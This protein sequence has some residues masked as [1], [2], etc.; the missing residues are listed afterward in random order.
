MSE[1]EKDIHINAPS[2]RETKNL[3]VS[4]L[5]SFW[6]ELTHPKPNLVMRTKGGIDRTF[7]LLIILL[8]LVGSIMIFSSSYVYSAKK[9]GDAM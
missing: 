8:L 2:V 4:E 7:L 9:L 3:I 6:H 1:K 5:K